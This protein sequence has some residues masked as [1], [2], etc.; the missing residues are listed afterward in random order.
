MRIG[1][2]TDAK[3]VVRKYISGTRSH[4]KVTSIVMDEKAKGPDEKGTW[5]MGG[6]YIRED[7]DTEQ[8]TASVS[9]R[10]EVSLTIIPKLQDTGGKHL[11]KVTKRRFTTP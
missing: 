6:S 4:G 10:G 7:G 8:F 11:S 1:N 5:T 2:E 9:S 3:G